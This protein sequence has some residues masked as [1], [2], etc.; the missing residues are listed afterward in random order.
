MLFFHKKNLLNEIATSLRLDGFPTRVLVF[1]LIFISY[2]VGCS[3]S[4]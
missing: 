4:Q 3:S 2:A 1:I